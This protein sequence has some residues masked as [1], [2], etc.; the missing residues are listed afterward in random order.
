MKQPIDEVACHLTL[1]VVRILSDKNGRCII[2]KTLLDEI[3]TV[4]K[5]ELKYQEGD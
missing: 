5:Q 4:F 1:S 3:Q 2:S